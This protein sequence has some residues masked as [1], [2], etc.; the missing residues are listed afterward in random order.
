MNARVAS[1]DNAGGTLHITRR[2]NPYLEDIEFNILTGRPE[3]CIAEFVRNIE[4][5]VELK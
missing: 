4:H 5:P 1:H 3:E 2:A